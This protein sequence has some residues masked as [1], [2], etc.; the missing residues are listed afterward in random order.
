MTTLLTRPMSTSTKA[1]K[2]WAE[3]KYRNTVRHVLD[4]I[5][6]MKQ[7]GDT[8]ALREV[9]R[10]LDRRG[11]R[12][13]R[14]TRDFAQWKI[15]VLTGLTEGFPW[16]KAISLSGHS[17]TPASAQASMREY[18]RRVYWLCRQTNLHTAEDFEGSPSDVGL[19]R[20]WSGLEL[21]RDRVA[22]AEAYKRGQRLPSRSR[23]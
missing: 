2:A 14:K 7:H 9:R 21:P 6:I 17:V 20:L 19:L 16:A 22:F 4:G 5:R 18:C 8:E 15:K 12:Q 11:G 23:K 3:H 13:G 1:E 10:A